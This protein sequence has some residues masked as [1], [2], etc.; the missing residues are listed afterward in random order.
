MLKLIACLLLLCACSSNG[1]SPE[2]S[3]EPSP[4]PDTEGFVALFNG[5]DLSGWTLV[6]TAPSTWTV[7]DGL[8]HCSGKPTGQLRTERM[9]QN[10]VLELEWRHLVP[11]GNAGIFLWADDITA[12]GVPFQRS[13]E[14]QVLDHAYGNT[15]SHTTHG[16][17]FP[18]HGARMTPINGRGGSRAFPTESRSN[19][20]PEWNHYRV[21]CQAGAISLE[22]NGKLVT[23]GTACSPSQGYICLESEGGQVDYR[24]IRLRELPATPIDAADSATAARGFE[25]LYNGLDLTGFRVKGAW[26]TRDWV[27]SHTGDSTG[28]LTTEASYTDFAFVLDVRRKEHTGP[29]RLLLRGHPAGAIDFGTQDTWGQGWHRLEGMLKGDSLVLTLDGKPLASPM[30]AELPVSGPLHIEASGSLDLANYYIVS[31]PGP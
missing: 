27:L 24:N 23:Q 4:R 7:V 15:N 8:L 20:S 16:D 13:I 21:T 1:S 25:T 17:I 19:P 12:K 30:Q 11:G 14:V 29:A 6:N 26:Q 22:V 31:L 18:I 2:P 10:F 3:P 28:S 9:Y 5:Q